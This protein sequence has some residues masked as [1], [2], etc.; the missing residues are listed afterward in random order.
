MY[1]AACPC[2][3]DSAWISRRVVCVSHAAKRS[4]SVGSSLPVCPAM[5][6]RASFL[7]RRVFCPACWCS[8]HR[9]RLLGGVPC[10]ASYSSASR[11]SSPVIATARELNRSITSWATPPTSAPFPSS[12][13]TI[14]YPSPVSLVSMIRSVTAATASR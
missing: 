5:V 10:A 2:T 7:V 11:L 4:S 6:R 1:A 3:C 9:V 13:G 14:T 8:S 12:R